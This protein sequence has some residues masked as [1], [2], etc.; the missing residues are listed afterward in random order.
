MD[1]YFSQ[2]WGLDVKEQGASVAGFCEGLLIYRWG[3]WGV[4]GR[5]RRSSLVSSCGH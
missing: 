5:E 2:F 1:I 4:G 3:G